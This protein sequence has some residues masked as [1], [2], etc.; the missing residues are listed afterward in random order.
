[1]SGEKLFFEPSWQAPPGVRALCTL[2]RAGSFG[3]GEDERRAQLVGIAGL[4][5]TPAWLTQVHGIGVE[6]LDAPGIAHEPQADASVTARTGVVCAILT[7]DCLPVLLAA[8]DGSVVGAAHAGW[9]G[10][11]AGVIEATVQRLRKGR[12]EMPLRAWLGP[13]I[14]AAHFEVGDE[15]R[16]A[17]TDADAG[18]AAAF[19][20]NDRGRWQC[21]LYQLARRRLAAVGVEDVSG[22]EHCTYAEVPRF[23]SHRRDVG[24]GRAGTTGRMAT[25]IWRQ[26]E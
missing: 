3:R 13:A 2:R 11:A 5:A 7:A 6:D 1:M 24:G 4:P 22:A 10:L 26:G 16:A 8:T 23:F 20:R 18:A 19:L 15:V 9:R 12:A 21:D 25:L 17:F 14:S